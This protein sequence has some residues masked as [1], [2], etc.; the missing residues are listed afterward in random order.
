MTCCLKHFLLITKLLFDTT[1][2]YIIYQPKWDIIRND[3]NELKNMHFLQS[4]CINTLMSVYMIVC[5]TWQVHSI[6]FSQTS[7]ILSANL[8]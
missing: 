1:I 3:D 6:Q 4:Q 5:I 2:I 7:V 8:H